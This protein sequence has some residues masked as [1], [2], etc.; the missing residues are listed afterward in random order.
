MGKGW[1]L[2]ARRSRVGLGIVILGL[3]LAL[4]FQWQIAASSP[5]SDVEL[6]ITAGRN[7]NSITYNIMVV[8]KSAAAMGNV[9]I[10]AK[11]PQGT[12]FNAVRNSPEGST[13]GQLQGSTVVWLT[14]AVAAK[15]KQGPF[16]YNV[17]ATAPDVGPANAW[18][19]WLSPSEGT[20]TSPQVGADYQ[21]IKLRGIDTRKDVEK[22]PGGQVALT[23]TAGKG[24]QED[25]LITSG[26]PNVGVGDYVYFQGAD[27]DALEMKIT[28]W[29]WQLTAKPFGSATVLE[30]ASTQTPR[31]RTDRVGS[32]RVNLAVINEKGQS[33][34]SAMVINSGRYAGITLCASCHNGTV[35]EDKITEFMKTGHATKFETTYASYS[36]DSDYCIRCHTV[37]YNEAADN[38]GMD[39]M[40]RASGWN[41]KLGSVLAWLKNG[42]KTLND[43]KADPNLSL[44][45]NIQCENCHGPGG[46]AHTATK[47]LDPSVCGQCHPQPQQWSYS[48]HT[49]VNA[50]M[51]TNASCAKCH[52]GQGYI[53]GLQGIA[54]VMPDEATP[55]KPANIP[56]LEQQSGIACA[57]CHDPHAFT[58]PFKSG[59]EEKSNQLRVNGKVTAPMGW[60]VDAGVAATCVKCHSDNRTPT[61]L[62]DFVAGTRTRGTHENTQADVFFGKGYY[63]Y[64]GAIKVT[65]SAHPVLLKD[66]CVTCHM[67]ANPTVGPGPDPQHP[68]KALSVGGHSFA[69]DGEWEGKKVENVAVCATCHTGATTFNRPAAGDYDG[70]GKVDGVQDEVKGLLA[71]LA[72][73][74]PKDAQGQVMNSPISPA[75]STEAQ[76]KALWNYFLIN[77]D[78]SFGVHNTSFAVQ[79][80]QQTYKQLTGRDIPGAT[81]R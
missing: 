65:N 19:R 17:T 78:G 62:A 29:A 25:Q 43:V 14:T 77:N 24:H 23:T 81:L 58:N 18:A 38:G 41:P 40:A 69:M 30:N 48:K 27:H 55:A 3:L 12:K 66:A 6:E 59:A 49:I 7:G 37:G 50:H 61:N 46:S 31:L 11:V 64:G 75:N 42:G 22:L 54:P 10:A 33:A 13:P 5:G 71:R 72:E 15:G 4:G 80:L 57:T 1:W 63:D 51:A 44:T 47:S 34:S 79:L 68:A 2:M 35:Q 52:T 56:S 67:A 20:A 60:S 28:S 21:L 39:D 73:L 9:Y 32:Y 76:R 45:I 36:K 53:L 26:L 74:L 16:S 70:D 8:N